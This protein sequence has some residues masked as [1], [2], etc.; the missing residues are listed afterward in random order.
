MGIKRV[1]AAFGIGGPSIDT[2]VPE[3]HTRPG[4][5]LHG[6]IDLAGGEVDADIDEIAVSL[7]A[8]VEVE[9]GDYEGQVTREFH[10]MAVTGPF[11]LHAGEQ[12]RVP[13][14]YRVTYQSPLTD[15]GGRPLPGAV[16]GLD[17]DVVIGGAPDKGDLDLIRIYPLPAQDRILE[18]AHRL[19]FALVKTDIEQ[20][21]LVGTRQE[22]PLY[23]ELEFRAAPQYAGRMNEMELSF[24]ADPQGVEVVIEVDKRGGLF[25]ESQDRFARFRIE[26]A[27]AEQGG[28]W[29]PALA[30]TVDSMLQ[31]RGIFG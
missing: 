22:F 25:T 12:R 21:R 14:T 3:P 11:R 28:D 30:Q 26:H 7:A 4:Q 19:G 29:A 10:R 17:T 16:V 2:V 18:A 27:Q 8:R 31:S 5:E 20:G 6:Y 24:V 23:Q 13:F 1:L 15:A 9:S